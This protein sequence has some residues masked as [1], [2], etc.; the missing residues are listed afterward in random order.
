MEK[1]LKA[2][3]FPCSFSYTDTNKR[4]KAF[5]VQCSGHQMNIRNIVKIILMYLRVLIQMCFDYLNHQK[6]N[7]ICLNKYITHIWSV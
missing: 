7:S 3:P 1:M 4:E 5:G 6:S 2:F